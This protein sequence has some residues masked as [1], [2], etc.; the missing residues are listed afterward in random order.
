MEYKVAEKKLERKK[1]L[2][3]GQERSIKAESATHPSLQEGHQ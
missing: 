2:S 1:K 3:E